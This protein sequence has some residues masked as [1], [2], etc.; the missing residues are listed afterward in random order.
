MIL[1]VL[2]AFAA[3]APMTQVLPNGV[4][5]IVAPIIDSNYVSAQALVRC[6]S[7]YETESTS[8]VFH[9]LEHLLFRS[10]AG[11]TDAK[12]LSNATTYAEFMC[13]ELRSGKT[14]DFVGTLRTLVDA[15]KS[16][17]EEVKKECN[18]I[19]EEIAIQESD[20]R[21]VSYRNLKKSAFGDSPWSL[22]SSGIPESV[23]R[24]TLSDAMGAYRKAF[25]GKNLIVVVAGEIEPSQVLKQLGKA[26]GDIPIGVALKVPVLPN[27]NRTSMTDGAGFFAS[28]IRNTREFVTA[29]LLA[30]LVVASFAKDQPRLFFGPSENGS[31]LALVGDS[32]RIDNRILE[33]AENGPGESELQ[34]AK[35][36]LLRRNEIRSSDPESFALLLGI[37]ELFHAESPQRFD[38][39]I[40]KVTI[41]E[42]QTIAL[43]WR[44]PRS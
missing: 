16:T 38:E 42:L 23:T 29:E 33:L 37:C 22:P 43:R 24:L 19:I 28:G 26:F 10:P 39:E 35:Q 8:G 18:I 17:S 7:A 41:K 1:G 25:V 3:L 15:P 32:K 36:A 34:Q 14:D 4:T 5:L 21:F 40:S 31:L 6:G 13:I 27:I 9:L 11:M 2:A 20:P 12:I 44:G 30:Q